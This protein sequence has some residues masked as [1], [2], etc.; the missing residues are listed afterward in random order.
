VGEVAF[1]DDLLVDS[2]DGGEKWDTAHTSRA[3]SLLLLILERL[4][5][6]WSGNSNSERMLATTQTRRYDV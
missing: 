3:S 1:E 2:A 5:V 6:S 4:C